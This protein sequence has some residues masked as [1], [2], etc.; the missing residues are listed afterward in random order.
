[1]EN[2]IIF[3]AQDR[4]W[5]TSSFGNKDFWLTMFWLPFM[6]I[7]LIYCA[8]LMMSVPHIREELMA[9]EVPS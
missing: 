2:K 7:V 1:M 8:A 6:P 5:F 3:T 4:S 9:E